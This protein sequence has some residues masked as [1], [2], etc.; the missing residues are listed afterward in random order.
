MAAFNTRKLARLSHLLAAKSRD[1]VD[2]I[3]EQKDLHEKA[4]LRKAITETHTR[5]QKVYHKLGK[6]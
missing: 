1:L 2:A 4:E 3:R 5:M 6:E